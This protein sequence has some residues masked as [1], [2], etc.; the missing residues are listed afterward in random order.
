[1]LHSGDLESTRRQMDKT[2]PSLKT[3]VSINTTTLKSHKL[4]PCGTL[5]RACA[6]CEISEAREFR[7][8]GWLMAADYIVALVF[9]EQSI[10][11][12]DQAAVPGVHTAEKI[13]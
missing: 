10:G 4:I 9:F 13:F 1:M 6:F 11:V 12:R 8:H 7:G 5:Y 3:T 2:H